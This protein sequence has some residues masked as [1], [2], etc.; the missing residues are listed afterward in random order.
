MSFILDYFQQRVITKIYENSILG[1]FWAHSPRFPA[2]TNISG[3]S[4]PVTF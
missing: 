2:N 4:T 1:P 3:K